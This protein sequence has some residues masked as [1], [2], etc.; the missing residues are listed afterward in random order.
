MLSVS[1]N[2]LMTLNTKVIDYLEIRIF[3]ITLRWI[4]GKS[5]KI[6]DLTCVIKIVG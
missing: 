4:N 1:I 5:K 3:I 6:F 2:T